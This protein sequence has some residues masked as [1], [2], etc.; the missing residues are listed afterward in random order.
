MFLTVKKTRDIFS[1][2]S[3]F[4][5][6]KL[7]WLAKWCTAVWWLLENGSSCWHLERV[8]QFPN[9]HRIARNI[10]YVVRQCL[11][12]DL[13]LVKDSSSTWRPERTWILLFLFLGV[14]SP[15]AV[16]EAG[17]EAQP[18]Q[19]GH[20]QGRSGA[21]DGIP[22]HHGGSDGPGKEHQVDQGLVF[23]DAGE[24]VTRI[25]TDSLVNTDTLV[26]IF[27][28]PTSFI[29]C[30]PKKRGVQ[31]QFSVSCSPYSPSGT[32]ASSVKPPSS[33]HTK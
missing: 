5:F 31:A 23:T 1:S 33:F 19:V 16:V 11:V 10:Q 21:A 17:G 15:Y 13:R 3:T 32:S 18:G 26:S 20:H 6:P 9:Y 27:S 12:F 4:S 8:T 2:S 25:V 28:Q 14:V 24:R 30:A 22:G 7:K 29:L